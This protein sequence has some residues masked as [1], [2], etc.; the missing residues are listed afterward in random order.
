MKKSF[1]NLIQYHNATIIILIVI[2][3]ILGTY[4][5]AQT[6]AGQEIIG[7]KQEKVIS[8][9]NK[10]LLSADLDNFD[11]QF[12]I[13]D[14]LSDNASST[15]ENYYVSYAYRNLILENNIWQWQDKTKTLEIPQNFLENKDLGA[16]IAEE[17]SEVAFWRQKELKEEQAK[18]EKIGPTE[19]KVVSEYS[20]LIG[21]VLDLKAAVF[22]GYEPVVE[23]ALI[24]PGEPPVLPTAPEPQSQTPIII[25]NNQDE[26]N[27][28]SSTADEQAAE[29]FESEPESAQ[30]TTEQTTEIP[31]ASEQL[32]T[33]E[34]PVVEE[35][36]APSPEAGLEPEPVAEQA[37]TEEAA[38]EIE[39]QAT[40]QTTE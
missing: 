11:M 19:K 29:E 13:L 16:Y 5:F 12:K 28:Q 38:P 27:Y 24:A 14:I 40:E 35:Q 33:T 1:F 7:A 34:P 20:G 6:D 37:P 15:P 10:E 31:A 32:T 8:V 26:N 4:V 36:P 30:Q 18:A 39:N 21:K 22:L 3:F 9:D 23:E 17:L 2:V 25:I